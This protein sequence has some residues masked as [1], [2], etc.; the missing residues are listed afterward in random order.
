MSAPGEVSFLA[1]AALAVELIAGGHRGEKGARQ[2]TVQ[3]RHSVSEAG[4]IV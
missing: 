3:H 2:R 4:G 1:K